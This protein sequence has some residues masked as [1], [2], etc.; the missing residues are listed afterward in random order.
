MILETQQK[1]GAQKW[2][3]PVVHF[4]AILCLG[5][6][7]QCQR[8]QFYRRPWCQRFYRDSMAPLPCE[9]E[10]GVA[11]L[12]HSSDPNPCWTAQ[13]LFFLE[14]SC[15]VKRHSNYFTR[16]LKTFF[17][18]LSNNVFSSNSQIPCKTPTKYSHKIKFP[19]HGSNNIQKHH[20]PQ[21]K[22]KSISKLVP[23]WFLQV[24]LGSLVHRSVPTNFKWFP[25][26]SPAQIINQQGNQTTPATTRK[27]PGQV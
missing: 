27:S 12:F 4:R 10:H 20:K 6:P 16:V 23:T 3:S 15:R 25:N 17:Q 1:T 5:V 7:I 18:L 9:N 13:S 22:R 24:P 21:N 11:A 26:S 2:T 8:L 14:E 19:G